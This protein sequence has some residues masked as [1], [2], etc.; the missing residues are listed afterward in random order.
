MKFLR[1]ILW[2]A[3]GIAILVIAGHQFSHFMGPETEEDTSLRP[4]FSLINHGGQPVTEETY[5][6]K[7]LLVFFGFTNCP[8][9]CPTTLTDLAS[10]M[11]GLGANTDQ[12][13]P[14]FISVDPQRD[15]VENIAEYV[16]AFHSS[17]VGLTGSNEDI[18]NAAKS[19]KAYFER[20]PDESVPDGYTMGHTS[21][22][23]LIS[24][25]GYF[26]RT[27]Q[28]GTLPEVIINDLK[29]RL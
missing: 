22:I 11:D 10:V 1:Y 25:D 19:F 6:G 18:A 24:P 3:I 12:V 7:W 29:G 21:A 28:F 16:T 4:T 20:V 14:L 2:S 15:R 5:R 8:D 17:I 27:H 23:Y 9:I 13:A 26:V